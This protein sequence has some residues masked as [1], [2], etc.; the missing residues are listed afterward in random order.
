MY[1]RELT[2]LLLV[3][4]QS[5]F[6]DCLVESMKGNKTF[7]YLNVAENAFSA[8]LKQILDKEKVID[9]FF[10]YKSEFMRDYVRTNNTI[11]FEMINYC[12]R[13]LPQILKYFDSDR[14]A[15]MG[16]LCQ[17]LS[18]TYNFIDSSLTTPD[19]PDIDTKPTTLPKHLGE[20]NT[21][22]TP[23]N[24]LLWYLYNNSAKLN[25]SLVQNDKQSAY[26]LGL[27]IHP[28]YGVDLKQYNYTYVDNSFDS[29]IDH[30]DIPLTIRYNID[31]FSVIDS[32]CRILFT[33]SSQRA[34]YDRSELAN[35]SRLYND[36]TD[37]ITLTEDEIALS[38][39]ETDKW[40]N[41]VMMGTSTLIDVSKIN[42][43]YAGLLIS[44]NAQF[45]P[46]FHVD[47]MFQNI[48]E[49]FKYY[50]GDLIH[51]QLDVLKYIIK[52]SKIETI[53]LFIGVFTGLRSR[54]LSTHLFDQPGN[55]LTPAQEQDMFVVEQMVRVL[56]LTL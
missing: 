50:I 41:Q 36:I 6:R 47:H 30:Y 21:E 33:T 42:S 45:N 44:R 18:P 2:R 39:V 53:R 22:T 27:N 28:N 20:A 24:D 15:L 1:R 31:T 34:T 49:C 14:Y 7:L 25:Y 4:G 23:Y 9:M 16:S 17:N 43:D 3:E 32:A 54:P 48:T 56:G 35:D 10:R 46:H 55:S 8:E 52:I 37:E 40:F 19:K 5:I 29:L 51:V 26:M 38:L 11:L 12:D 13:N